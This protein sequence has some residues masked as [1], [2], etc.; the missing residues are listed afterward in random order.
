MAIVLLASMAT[1]G[2][3]IPTHLLIGCCHHLA[4]VQ[5]GLI[6]VL[7]L[8]YWRLGRGTPVAAIEN[9]LMV[10]AVILFSTLIFT[11]TL[12]MTGAYWAAG[13]PF[14]SYFIKSV[15]QARWWVLLFFVEILAGAALA[16]SGAVQLP[17]SAV[18]MGCLAMV[19]GFFWLLAHIYQ[20]QY[21]S[22]R[23]RLHASYRQI[24]SNRA[25]LQTILDHAPNSIW[26]LDREGHIGFVNRAMQEWTGV[27]EEV[28]RRSSDYTELLPADIG[29]RCREADRLC[30][31]GNRDVYLDREQLTDHQGRPRCFDL[32]RVK[33]RDGNGQVIG[34]VGFAIDITERLEAEREHRRIERQMLHMQR[35]ESL[36]LMAGGV[37]HDFNN[38]LTVMQGGVELLRA[39]EHFSD[40][41]TESLDSIE[42]AIQAASELCQQMLAYSGKGF[43][44][45]D[46][47]DINALL[48]D[49][50]SLLRA[51]VGKSITLK[52]ELHKRPLRVEADPGQIRQIILNMVMNAAEAID[53]Q[54]GCITLRTGLRH[55][56][57]GERLQTGAD[58]GLAPGN[59]ALCEIIDTGAGMDRDTQ[60]RIFDPFFTTKFT[61]RG[62][63]MSAALGI[64]KAHRGGIAIE[65][66]PG[67]GTTMGIW[68]PACRNAGT[69]GNSMG[70]RSGDTSPAGE[71]WHGTVLLIDDEESV[72]RVAR[73]MLE[74]LGFDVL[75]AQNGR[76]GIELYRNR[77]ADIDWV[78]LDMTMPNM[79]GDQCFRCLQAINPDIRVI[80]SSGYNQE[81]LH[82]ADIPQPA[83]FLKKPYSFDQLRQICHKAMQQDEELPSG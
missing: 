72:I 45:T 28:L 31:Q 25:Q 1:L 56:S 22:Q 9:A 21:E 13:Y 46:I 32:I 80:L 39:G 4:A 49:M 30:L 77:Q 57:G 12:A 35:L 37:A 40:T 19:I 24:D 33:L 52:F 38:L 43:L 20:S 81:S 8:L 63:G 71:R 62:L 68:L 23:R 79:N 27:S 51:S 10:C 61:G 41:G 3:F 16:S 47:I 58:A 54:P 15:R 34:L 82:A 70:D 53:N 66:H 59:Y 26:M 42:S 29:R 14:V 11:E 5:G 36:G 44:K 2:V 73:R 83:A 78:L 64:I 74:R 48:R 67:R 18:Q 55:L 60:A 17:Y 76:D 75:C 69:T 7:A 65:S 6:P 50:R